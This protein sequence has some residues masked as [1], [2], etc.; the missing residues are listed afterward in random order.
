MKRAQLIE[1]I[2]RANNKRRDIVEMAKQSDDFDLAAAWETL[3][4]A[5]TS[6][7]KRITADRL[8]QTN[9]LRIAACCCC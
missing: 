1:D 2:E 7:N 4:E 8:K 9:E 5:E 6:I 3:E